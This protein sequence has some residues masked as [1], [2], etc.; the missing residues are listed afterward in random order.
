MA[1]PQGEDPARTKNAFNKYWGG[2]QQGRDITKTGM[3]FQNFRA[4]ES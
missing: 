1:V 4:I 3:T 2:S